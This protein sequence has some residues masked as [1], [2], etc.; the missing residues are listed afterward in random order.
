MEASKD[1]VLQAA[2]ARALADAI[3]PDIQKEV[4]K[5]AISNYLFRIDEQGKGVLKEAFQRALNDAVYKVAGEVVSTPEN[6]GK[7]KTFLHAALDEAMKE[8]AFV[9]RMRDKIVQA[10]RW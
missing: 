1:A 5:E 6:L 7:M 2:L 8:R 10:W 9:D 3:S 4:F